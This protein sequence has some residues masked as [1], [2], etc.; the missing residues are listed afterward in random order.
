MKT[1][2]ASSLF[3][4]DGNLITTDLSA[5]ASKIV[6]AE[7]G[8]IASDH[9]SKLVRIEIGLAIRTIAAKE[10]STLTDIIVA[11]N[12]CQTTH[13]A[14]KTFLKYA[15]IAGSKVLMTMAENPQISLSVLD[16]IAACK[17]PVLKPDE[18][19]FMR[20]VSGD[21]L[22]I[23]NQNLVDEGHDGDTGKLVV[24][25]ATRNEAVGVIRK[26]QIEMGV[27]TR[28]HSPHPERPDMKAIQSKILQLLNLMRIF[29]LPAN[30]RDE[31]FKKHGI[32]MADAGATMISLQ[33][34]LSAAG[35]ISALASDLKPESIQGLQ[36][37]EVIQEEEPE[38][39]PEPELQPI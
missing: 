10:K 34:D 21:I 17:K 15:R 6:E 28:A 18:A 35:I 37:P 39:K 23:C 2:Q 22:E 24:L 25:G 27:A 5:L 4:K 31:W 9:Q 14:E 38:A 3:D 11:M 20:R 1:Y 8:T 7:V 13:R 26:V 33:N 12:L 36:R 16:E 30:E 29:F 19:K 32:P